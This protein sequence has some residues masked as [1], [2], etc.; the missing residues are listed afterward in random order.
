MTIL[1]ES[2]LV[3][4]PG[5]SAALTGSELIPAKHALEVIIMFPAVQEIRLYDTQYERV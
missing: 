5:F 4:L 2:A 1:K 3:P